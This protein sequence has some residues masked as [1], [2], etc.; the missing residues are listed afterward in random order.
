MPNAERKGRIALVMP[1]LSRYGGAE[2][3]AWRLAEV[4]ARRGHEVDFICA[5]CETEPPPGVTPVVVGRFGGVRAV[6]VLWFALMAGR[7][8][9]RGGYDLVFGMGKTLGQDIL[10]IGGGPISTFWKLSAHAW[11]AGFPRWF[12]MARRRLSPSGWAIH[13][14]DSLRYR[15]TP[16]LVAVSHMVRD[17]TVAAYPDLDPSAIEVIYNKP[18][19]GRFS[20]VDEAQRRALRAEADIEDGQMVIGTAATN[21]TLKGVRSLLMALAR[22]PEHFVLHVAGGRGPGKYLRLARRLGVSDRVRFLGRVEDMA[23]FYRR[24][25]VFV[26]AT[27]YDAC[28]NAVLEALACGCRSVSSARN[29]SARFLPKRWV[30]SDPADVPELAA[31]L[32]RVSKEERPGPFVWPPEVPCGMDPYVEMIEQAIAR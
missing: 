3:F 19:L 2:S 4:L 27:F 17:W 5:R 14:I 10:R 18:D 28:S 30:F 16:H 23:S 12:K 1:R 6:K 11:P 9:R 32:L 25:D 21:F 22:L 26:L 15:R 8:R 24:L 29:G 20:P 31:V 13:W 7:A